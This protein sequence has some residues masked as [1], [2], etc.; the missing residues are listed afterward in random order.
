M[1][2]INKKGTTASEVFDNLTEVVIEALIPYVKVIKDKMPELSE[3]SDRELAQR[4]IS[5]VG[6]RLAFGKDIY[7]KAILKKGKL[8][9]IRQRASADQEVQDA[10][11]LEDKAEGNN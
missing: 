9:P 5:H 6:S 4:I 2:D 8:E 11:K 7:D 1:T 3:L 10:S